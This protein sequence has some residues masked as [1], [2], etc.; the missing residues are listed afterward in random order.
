MHIRFWLL[1]RPVAQGQVIQALH[2]LSCTSAVQK[3]AFRFRTSNIPLKAEGPSGQ[4]HTSTRFC[5]CRPF[6][7][8]LRTFEIDQ[9]SFALY[10]LC[11]V[12]GVVMSYD[13]FRW[14]RVHVQ[15]LTANFLYAVNRSD[16]VLLT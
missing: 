8:S 10:T 1:A 4:G 5:A 2:V 7:A 11:G 16:S 6:E 9:Y 3:S 15:L 12:P 13:A 14:N